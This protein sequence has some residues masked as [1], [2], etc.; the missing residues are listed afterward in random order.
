MFQLKNQVKANQQVG[1]FGLCWQLS[2]W[3]HAL[4][5]TGAYDQYYLDK[6]VLLLPTSQ[7]ALATQAE[8]L[9]LG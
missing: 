9:I 7:F 1:S 8:Q 5:S 4:F 3:A 6:E 2:S